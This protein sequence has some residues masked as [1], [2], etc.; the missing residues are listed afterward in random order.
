[1]FWMVV[2]AGETLNQNI[3]TTVQ[4]LYKKNIKSCAVLNYQNRKEELKLEKLI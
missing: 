3:C 4:C 2:C 1:M